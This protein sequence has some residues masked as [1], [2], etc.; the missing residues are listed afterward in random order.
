MMFHNTKK[1]NLSASL[2]LIFQN[3]LQ[4]EKNLICY[5]KLENKILF[6]QKQIITKSISKNYL[7]QA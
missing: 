3:G 6:I 7:D 5:I 2:F 1:A 4:T